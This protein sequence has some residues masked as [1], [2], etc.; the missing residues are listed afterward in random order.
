MTASW[1]SSRHF[2][3]SRNIGLGL[4]ALGGTAGSFLLFLHLMQTSAPFAETVAKLSPD[5]ANAFSCTCPFCSAA[6]QPPEN[7]QG[8]TRFDKGLPEF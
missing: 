1:T 5:I 2:R 6:C 8:L 4:A 3:R 7:E